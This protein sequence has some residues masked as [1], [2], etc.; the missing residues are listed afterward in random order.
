MQAY[1]LPPAWDSVIIK[2]WRFT[3]EPKAFA[4]RRLLA[5]APWD[6]NAEASAGGFRADGVY[7]R[8]QTYKTNRV[9]YLSELFVSIKCSNLYVVFN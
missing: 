1:N 3:T 6:A 4:C 9:R 8:G 5:G 7:S 2:T